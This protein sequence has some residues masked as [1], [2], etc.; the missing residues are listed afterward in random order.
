VAE[1]VLGLLVDGD[2]DHIEFGVLG[3]NVVFPLT[4]LFL[5]LEGNAADRAPK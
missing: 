4:L 3:D 1:Q 5:E 2:F